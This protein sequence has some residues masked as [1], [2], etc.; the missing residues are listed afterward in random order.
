MEQ[1]KKVDKLFIKGK[2]I[3]IEEYIKTSHPEAS[4]VEIFK[5]NKYQVV[6]SVHESNQEGTPSLVWLSIKNINKKP[7]H[8]WRDLQEIKNKLV[9][10]ECE[11]LELFP[12]ESRKT[13]MAN[14]YHLWCF[15]SPVFRLPFGFQKGITG[16]KKNAEKFGAKQRPFEK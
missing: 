3:S 15:D 10:E 4:S 1:F 6:K 5:N 16:D 13:D 14:Q 9:G 12:A 7:I 11:G 8:D 2:E